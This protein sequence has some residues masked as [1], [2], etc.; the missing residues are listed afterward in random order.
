VCFGPWIA[1]SGQGPPRALQPASMRSTV[2]PW[3]KTSRKHGGVHGAS[4]RMQS[5]YPSA[6]PTA[7]NV[8]LW[9]CAPLSGMIGVR[10]G[11]RVGAWCAQGCHVSTRVGMSL[12]IEIRSLMI[13]IGSW[14]YFFVQRPR[15]RPSTRFL[16]RVLPAPAPGVDQ[17]RGRPTGRGEAMF[18]TARKLREGDSE[19]Q[20][21]RKHDS[22]P[23][24]RPF[25][26]K[27]RNIR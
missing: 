21:T 14:R 10:G 23:C 9:G 4:V 11:A 27:K 12:M 24:S 6:D 15:P 7:A 18:L 19:R 26:L 17:V 22:G 2:D 20:T 13:E 1:Y 5:R 8:R 25:A 16:L 3:Q